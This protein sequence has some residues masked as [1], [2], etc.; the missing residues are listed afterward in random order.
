[1]P[2]PNRPL[3]NITDGKGNL[4]DSW[5]IMFNNLI[6]YLQRNFTEFGI[7]APHQDQDSVDRLNLKREEGNFLYN[8]DTQSHFSNSNGV[9]KN[10]TTLENLTTDEIDNVPSGQ[11]DGRF[12]GDTDTG[13]LKIGVNDTILTV[14]TT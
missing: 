12:F 1:M 9:L 4:S 3:D 13:E 11:R 2:I 5:S 8:T 6:N 14:T 10:M 7:K